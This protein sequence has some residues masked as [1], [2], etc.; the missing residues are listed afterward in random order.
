VAGRPQQLVALVGAQPQR[1]G[2]REHFVLVLG[3]PGAG[4]G[5]GEQGRVQP[6]RAGERVG[7]EAAARAV[8]AHQAAVAP[9]AAGRRD[10]TDRSDTIAHAADRPLHI[11]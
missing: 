11:V 10:G 5:P 8:P 3:G 1:P 2:E 7:G 6:D 9:F 4:L